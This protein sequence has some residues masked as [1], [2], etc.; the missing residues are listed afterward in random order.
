MRITE[1]VVINNCIYA[2]DDNDLYSFI[3]CFLFNR[4]QYLKKPN[5]KSCTAH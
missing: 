4:T 5:T 2:E 3:K 1:N